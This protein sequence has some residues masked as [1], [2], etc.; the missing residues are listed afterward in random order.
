MHSYGKSVSIVGTVSEIY[1][2]SKH[3]LLLPRT[4]PPVTLPTL[5]ETSLEGLLTETPG[6][7]VGRYIP[8]VGGR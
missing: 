6:T 5:H 1:T 8:R 7:F 2:I 4:M 3:K